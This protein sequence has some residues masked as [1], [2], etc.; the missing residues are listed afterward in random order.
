MPGDQESA[1]SNRAGKSRQDRLSSLF[2][3]VNQHVSTNHQI[4]V[5]TFGERL[6]EGQLDESDLTLREIRVIAESFKAT[7]RAVYHP[8]IEYPAPSEAERRR[9]TAIPTTATTTTEPAVLPPPPI[10]LDERGRKRQ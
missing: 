9:K 10:R 2:G 6:A 1:G 8:R 4:G 5:Q 7:L 3:E